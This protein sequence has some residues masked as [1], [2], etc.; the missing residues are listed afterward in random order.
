MHYKS[1]IDVCE[2]NHQSCLYTFSNFITKF[3]SSLL[4]MHV[5]DTSRLWHDIFN[6]MYF[7]YMQKLDK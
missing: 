5:D 7:K 3:D 2:V 6:H 4:L 1:M